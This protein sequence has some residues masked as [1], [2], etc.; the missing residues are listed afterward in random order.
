MNIDCPNSSF[1]LVEQQGLLAHLS[2][3]VPTLLINAKKGLF[4][5]GHII[6]LE[7]PGY[8]RLQF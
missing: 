8:M 5:F 2:P 3:L 7:A 1:A 6:F 4:H